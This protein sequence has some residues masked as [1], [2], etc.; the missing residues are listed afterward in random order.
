MKDA[1]FISG[2]VVGLRMP[3]IDDDILN[4]SWHEWFNDQGITEFL[5]HG[6]F[7]V[8]RHQQAAFITS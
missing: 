5:G 1:P 7:P 2:T 6:V 3:N 4:G 8:N